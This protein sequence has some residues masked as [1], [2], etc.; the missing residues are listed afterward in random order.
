[1]N[2]MAMF[3][4]M[5]TVY[6]LLVICTDLTI[7]AANGSLIVSPEGSKMITLGPSHSSCAA[8]FLV[9]TNASL[10]I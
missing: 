7:A 6:V 10:Q 1:M 8:A 3:A 9:G 4:E 2:E 5:G